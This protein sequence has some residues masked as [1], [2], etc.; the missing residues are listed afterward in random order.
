MTFVLSAMHTE[1]AAQSLV[2]TCMLMSV[3]GANMHNIQDPDNHMKFVSSAAE[4][5]C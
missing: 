4:L 5:L 1:A 3:F 2:T